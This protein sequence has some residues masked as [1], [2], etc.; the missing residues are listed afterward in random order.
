MRRVTHDGARP[1]FSLQDAQGLLP[2]V[3]R[4][5]AEAIR[6]AE[7]AT[8]QL[9]RLR[10]G[11]PRRAQVSAELDRVVADWNASIQAMGLEAKGLWLVDF[12]NGEGYY[13]WA[14]PEDRITHFHSYED[15]FAGRMK[16]V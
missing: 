16:I 11:D 2:E 13:C 10:E 1:V 3:K 15:G 7:A 9:E 6:G 8:A 5:T 12:D 4:I 14:H